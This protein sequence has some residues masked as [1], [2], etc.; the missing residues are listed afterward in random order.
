M[1]AW[2]KRLNKHFACTLPDDL[3]SWFDGEL[4]RDGRGTLFG[5][6]NSPESLMDRASAKLWGGMYLPD[7]L[8]ILTDGSEA[9]IF[10]RF[11][12]AGDV[13]D[14]VRWE[15]DGNW[16]VC[17]RSMAECVVLDGLGLLFDEPKAC[18]DR[19]P[20]WDAW[21]FA[22]LQLPD[23]PK[24]SQADYLLRRGLGLTAIRQQRCIAALQSGF[25][26]CK[27]KHGIW[28]IARGLGVNPSEFAEGSFDHAK[29]PQRMHKGLLSYLGE[30]NISAV[31]Q[32]DW[33]GAA[34]Q[35]KLAARA[36]SDMMWP[37]AVMGYAAERK[38]F[39]A[40]AARHYVNGTHALGSSMEFRWDGISRANFLYQHLQA[41]SD[42]FVGSMPAHAA[43][44]LAAP[45]KF[46]ASRA[47]WYACAAWA[48]KA[49]DFGAVYDTLY[50]AGWD[51]F[52]TNDTDDL[53]DRMRIA[54]KK[55]GQRCRMRILEK[56][57]DGLSPATRL[58]M[59]IR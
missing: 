15:T 22:L 30:R 21:A 25:S 29:I 52:S 19:D 24:S 26:R 57:I 41:V 12:A 10:A 13:K 56:Y 9:V 23:N 8:P 32:Q 16:T 38:G 6:P 54:A 27:N 40:Q 47:Y 3:A 35:A 51:D 1:T 45:E 53:M 17:A 46:R 20:A 18:D 2:S 5:E 28:E 58:R 59:V 44:I 42:H 48:E 14:Y 4:W 33:D 55:S 43:A 34:Q 7:C 31:V 11:N 50:R 36:A 39:L 37:Y 49:G